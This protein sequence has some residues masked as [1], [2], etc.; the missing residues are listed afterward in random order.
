MMTAPHHRSPCADEHRVQCDRAQHH[1][2]RHV[3]LQQTGEQ[4]DQRCRDDRDVGP[5][6]SD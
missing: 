1:E 3:A 5:R 4:P 6:Y 2:E